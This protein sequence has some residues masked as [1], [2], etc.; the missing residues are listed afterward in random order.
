M[1][2]LYDILLNFNSR[3]YDVFEW[4]KSDNIIHIRK[5]LFFKVKSKTL[6]EILNSKFELSTDFLMNIYKRTE[7]FSKNKISYIDYAFLLTD[8]REVVAVRYSDKKISYSKLL[9]EEELDALEY[10]YNLKLIDIEY[11]II[12]KVKIDYFKTRNEIVIKNY[13]FRELNKIIKD[14]DFDKLNYLYLECFNEKNCNN[15]RK[16]IYD[17]LENKWDE[18]YMKVYDFLKMTVQKY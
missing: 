7:V 6:Y 12:S 14:N 11:N 10:S 3:L 18:V 13:I 2:Y 9:Y 15:V 16:D 5:I 4:E 8:G 1:N 17:K